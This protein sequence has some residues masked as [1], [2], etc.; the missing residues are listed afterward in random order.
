[1]SKLKY[2]DENIQDWKQLA[3]SKE[4]FDEKI[5]Q[6]GI[7]SSLTTVDKTSLVG[8]TN[9]VNNKVNTH[10]ADYEYQV[11][12]IVGTQVRLVK[13]S[14]TNILKFKLANVLSG[15][16][17]TISLDNGATSKPL[18]SVDGENITE[19]DK[20]FVEVI[21]DG[22][23]FT[24][25]PRGSLKEFFGDGS[26]GV[27]NTTGNIS[28]PSTLNGAVTIRQY[29][30][31]KINAGHILT[32]TNPCQGLVLYSQGDVEI[33][34]IIDMSQK[35]GL[36]SNGHVVPVLITNLKKTNPF[37]MQFYNQLTTVLQ[38][39]KGG[40]GGNGGQGGGVAGNGRSA[41]GA[42]GL[43]R[44]NQGGFGGGGGGGC[45]GAS[46]PGGNGGSVEFAELGG[47]DSSSIAI[48]GSSSPS[49]IT[50]HRYNGAGGN[51]G[52]YNSFNVTSSKGGKCFGGG[53]GGSGG[54]NG[55]S[56]TAFSFTGIDGQYAGG[57]ILII[58]K[59]DITI[60]STGVIRANG[61]NGGNGGNSA[62]TFA[63]AGGGGGG[64]AGGGV[65]AIF[66]KKTYANNGTIQVNGGSG[67][68]GGTGN[69][70]GETGGSGVA[71]AV[72]TIHIQ[73]I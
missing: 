2:F 57:F 70:T 30:S 48:N 71:G 37:G 43:G 1:M 27:L 67:G 8:A 34:G 11:P 73:Q 20:G 61:G 38:S 7:L 5:N 55:S 25:R 33:N 32:T 46:A 65:I 60:G 6:I 72:G 15:G 35:A 21:N 47:G 23:N 22:V 56:S 3:P 51:G 69:G 4:E 13:Q 19:L 66:H 16:N 59:G 12:T 9:E 53:G 63:S 14:D 28:L 26:D 18:Q 64:G 29:Q 42:R 49:N 50:I 54:A 52:L 17:I 44:I 45:A 68:S 40:Q 39:L 41:G 36:A 10:L 24:L 31:I 62:A 58:A